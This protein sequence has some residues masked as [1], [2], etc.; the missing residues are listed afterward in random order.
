MVE[1]HFE[2]WDRLLFR[3]YHIDHPETAREYATLKLHLSQAHHGDRVAYTQARTDFILRITGTA[4][5]HYGRT[6]RRA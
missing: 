5:E 2:H 4:K 3:D 6:R 1:P